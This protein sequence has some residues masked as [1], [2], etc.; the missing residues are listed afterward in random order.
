LDWMRILVKI[1]NVTWRAAETNTNFTLQYR[2]LLHCKGSHKVLRKA[3]P[4]AQHK[5][6]ARATKGRARKTRGFAQVTR[7]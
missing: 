3:R 1:K 5:T 7:N 6:V 2:V 4:K